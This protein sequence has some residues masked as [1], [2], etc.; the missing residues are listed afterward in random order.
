[1]VYHL[2]GKGAVYKQMGKRPTKSL[3][4]PNTG[5]SGKGG[6]EPQNTVRA[7]QVRREKERNG[8]NEKKYLQN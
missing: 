3:P 1:M 6:P 8:G 2:R 7:G 5:G 4:E